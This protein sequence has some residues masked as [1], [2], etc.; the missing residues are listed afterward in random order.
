[1]RTLTH[2]TPLSLYK[3]NTRSVV[4]H[5][6]PTESTLYHLCLLLLA[7]LPRQTRQLA[8]GHWA[9]GRDM[10][11]SLAITSNLH[12][13]VGDTT[14]SSTMF[15]FSVAMRSLYHKQPLQDAEP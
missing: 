5:S 2:I 14:S 4:M 9:M 8:T 12:C 6:I 15:V 3:A 13:C 10:M 7:T 11:L 1:M